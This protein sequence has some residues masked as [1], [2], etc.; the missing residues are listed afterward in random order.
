M[1]LDLAL[2][3]AAPVSLVGAGGL[4]GL[5]PS[6]RGQPIEPRAPRPVKLDAV[7]Q[8]AGSTLDLAPAS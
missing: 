2:A 7:G 6:N 5:L 3:S 8:R 4:F 1:R